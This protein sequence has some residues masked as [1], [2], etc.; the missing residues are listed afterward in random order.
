MVRQTVEG[1]CYWPPA[2]VLLGPVQEG[3]F[4]VPDPVVDA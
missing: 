2:P 1:C 4:A 3:V